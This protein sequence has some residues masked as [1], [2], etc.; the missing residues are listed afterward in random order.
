MKRI[1]S[2]DTQKLLSEGW[3]Y[4][5][6]RTPQEF[7][8]GRPPGAINIP[9]GPNFLADIEKNYK[10]DHKLILGCAVGGRSFQA[11]AALEQSGYTQICDYGGGFADWAS[12]KLPTEK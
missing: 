2:T 4:V 11:A 5:D 10:P 9:L 6:V 8:A 3:T 7:A 1:N 12:K